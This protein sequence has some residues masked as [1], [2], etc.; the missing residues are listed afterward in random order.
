MTENRSQEV[1]LGNM[2]ASVVDALVKFCYSGEINISNANVLN[3]LSTAR[4]FQLDQELC[5]EFLKR[6]LEPSSSLVVRPVTDS[7]SCPEA[8]ENVLHNFENAVNTE[9]AHEILVNQLVEL[10]LNEELSVRLMA[11][12][13]NAV[14]RWIRSDLSARKQFL[15]ES[16]WQLSAPERLSKQLLSTHQK[17]SSKFREV[18]YVGMTK[19]SR[20]F[21]CFN[22]A[23]LGWHWEDTA[24][25]PENTSILGEKFPVWR[26]I[27]SMSITRAYAGVAALDDLLYVVG[28]LSDGKRVNSAE[29]Y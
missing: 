9:K 11:Q 19:A 16:S 23:I 15:S 7:I 1:Y 17:D 13:V 28:G 3:I 5:R 29:R 12:I 18:L 24:T 20:F 27:P 21:P 10:I 8:D 6:K 4:L 25:L 14:L 22:I 2:E 26:R